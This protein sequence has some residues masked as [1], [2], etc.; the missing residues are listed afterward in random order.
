[1]KREWKILSIGQAPNTSSS[2][3][4]QLKQ[5]SPKK[6]CLP[7]FSLKL[8][9]SL[10]AQVAS[11]VVEMR[12]SDRQK[13][14]LDWNARMNLKKVCSRSKDCYFVGFQSK[15][16]VKIISG[17]PWLYPHVFY[18][19]RSILLMETLSE[20]VE[21]LNLK[22]RANWFFNSICQW[23][24][25]IMDS[26]GRASSRLLPY[27]SWA[28]GT[29]SQTADPTQFLLVSGIGSID[30]TELRE[31]FFISFFY[32]ALTVFVRRCYLQLFQ[33]DKPQG[34]MGWELNASYISCWLHVATLCARELI[35]RKTKGPFDLVARSS[36]LGWEVEKSLYKVFFV[37]QFIHWVQ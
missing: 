24:D 28:S 4:L 34:W 5:F 30:S 31:I 36:R 17:L 27:Q 7:S 10:L 23:G 16:Y 6:R 11:Q 26:M 18:S 9:L 13:G 32:D 21:D 35:D 15:V 20:V 2:L 12:S 25:P 14:E 19:Y 22:S 29:E 33:F 37:F 8:K 3:K 1:M